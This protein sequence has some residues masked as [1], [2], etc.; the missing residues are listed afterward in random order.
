MIRGDTNEQILHPLGS[1]CPQCGSPVSRGQY[2]CSNCEADR[3]RSAGGCDIVYKLPNWCRLCDCDYDCEN[4]EPCRNEQNK[5][6]EHERFTRKMKET[7]QKINN[8]R[9]TTK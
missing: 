1:I 2:L 5:T 4:C 8:H 6:G 3:D 7:Q 9:R